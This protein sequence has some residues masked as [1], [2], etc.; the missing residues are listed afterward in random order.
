MPSFSKVVLAFLLAS[1][2]VV[3]LPAPRPQLHGEGVA[4]DAIFT[5]TDNGVGYGVEN[6]EDNIAA[7]IASVKGG[8]ATSGTGSSSGGG[9]PPPPP[10]PGHRRRQADKISNGFQAISNAAGTGD[11]TKAATDELDNLDGLSTDGAANTGTQLG[12]T[13]EQ[14]LEGTG[15]AIPKL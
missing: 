10:P 8:S 15:K 13:E 1:T 7:N 3:A 6:A 4:A 14:A 11:S 5:D 12:S 2:A 9:N